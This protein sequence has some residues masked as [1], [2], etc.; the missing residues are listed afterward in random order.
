MHLYT[1]H[2]DIASH[3]EVPLM[4]KCWNVCPFSNT[5]LLGFIHSITTPHNTVLADGFLAQLS[6]R[7]QRT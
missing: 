2:S 7:M 1:D 6:M 3:D 5:H 4:T